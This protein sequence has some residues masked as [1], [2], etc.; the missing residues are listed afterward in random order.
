MKQFTFTERKTYDLLPD[1][2][3]LVY[4]N[5][6]QA[7]EIDTH[8]D[9]SEET[10]TV[11]RY[12]RTTAENASRDAII[13]AL[14]RVRY[15]T[16]DE[17]ALSRQKDA[18]IGEYNTYNAY[19]EWCKAYAKRLLEGDTLASAKALKI[20]G[21]LAYDASTEVNSFLIN[22]QSLWL[23]PER[24]ANY[25]LTIE[26]AQEAGVETVP[27]EGINLPVATA[28]AA[29]KAI[30]I[31]AMQCVAVTNAHEA[32]INALETIEAVDAYDYTI[33]YPKKLSF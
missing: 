25:L 2:R 18:K 11:W 13:S 20:A 29:L 21:L 5:E 7:T 32:A 17:L 12:S 30:N 22:G 15:S 26:A 28:L 8:D 10:R 31:Y 1:G 24:R 4:F 3:A 14:I 23:S 9:G 19:A 33:G 6:V 16:D 27:F